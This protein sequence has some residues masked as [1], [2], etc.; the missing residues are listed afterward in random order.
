MHEIR[1]SCPQRN[2]IEIAGLVPA[3][4]KPSS[5][6]YAP[7]TVT[8]HL[9]GD[10]TC[11]ALDLT[12]Q[13]SSPV[14]ALCRKLIERAHDR[15]TGLEVY[16]GKTL[17]LRVRSIGQAARLEANGDGTGFRPATKAGRASLVR[18]NRRAAG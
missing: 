5:A 1:R 11:S 3:A 13:S 6:S 8:A 12:V 4:P 2:N 16:R 15:A 17:A 18:Q 9:Q 14:I 10:D 7:A